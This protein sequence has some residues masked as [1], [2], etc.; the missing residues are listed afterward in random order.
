VFSY[1]DGMLP[2]PRGGQHVHPN[3]GPLGGQIA[4]TF[5]ATNTVHGLPTLTGFTRTFAMSALVL[6]GCAVAGLLIPTR[7]RAITRLEPAATPET[8]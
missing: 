1:S 4:A 8:G 2:G 5:I 7:P 3:A 6:A